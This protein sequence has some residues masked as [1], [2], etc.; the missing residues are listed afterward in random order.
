MSLLFYRNVY[1]FSIKF[2]LFSS[3]YGLLVLFEQ[4]PANKFAAAMVESIRQSQS[5]NH[6]CV[7]EVEFVFGN[8]ENNTAK[9]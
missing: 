8:H 5:N 3:F 7:G 2:F 4:I 1:Y 9:E 6:A